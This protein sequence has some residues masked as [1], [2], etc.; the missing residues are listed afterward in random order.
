MH[1][2]TIGDVHAI[3]DRLD[4]PNMGSLPV[5]AFV[6]RAEEPVLVDTG[7]P[8]SRATFV[9][10][11]RSVIDLRE[12][13]WIWLTHPDRDHLGALDT[14]L[15][16]APQA[17]LVCTSATAGYLA[18]QQQVPEERVTVITPGESLP[19]GG[20]RRLQAFR[21]PLYDNPMTVG[22]LDSGNGACV[23]ADCF[24]A[25]LPTAE[26]ADAA[27]I[28]RLDAA[29]VQAGQTFWAGIDSPWVHLVDPE[30]FAASHDRLSRFQPR[31]MLSAHLPPAVDQFEHFRGL[32]A[33]LPRSAPD[34]VPAGDLLE[35]AVDAHLDRM[36]DR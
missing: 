3:R 8:G 32:L 9:D 30:L 25:V 1:I 7:L 27:D 4:I 18:L 19:V 17:R 31:L 10:A 33:A 29:E 21:P 11:V 28:A 24:G 5:N 35:Q 22:F 12:L 14:I 15:A 16:Q 2:N 6:V 13:T 23:S 36:T 34:Q 26:S 20:G